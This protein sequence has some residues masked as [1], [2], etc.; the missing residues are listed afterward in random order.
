MW[1]K[2]DGEDGV[3]LSIRLVAYEEG[4]ARFVG[5]AIATRAPASVW[6][7][8]ERGVTR[9]RLSQSGRNGFE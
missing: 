2:C 3:R 8:P 5:H 7:P 9:R 1:E 4:N 6:D